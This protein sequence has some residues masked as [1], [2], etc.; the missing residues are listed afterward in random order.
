MPILPIDD[1]HSSPADLPD[2]VGQLSALQSLLRQSGLVFLSDAPGIRSVSLPSTLHAFLLQLIPQLI[3]GNPL[4][5]EIGSEEL[6][7]Q[8]AAEIL[9]VSRPFLV[10]LLDFGKIPHYL[11]GKHRRVYRK[12]LLEYKQFRDLE[13]HQALNRIA[14]ADENAGIYDKV[15]LPED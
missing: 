3:R 9:G 10:K 14:R 2:P 12:D 5:M 7:T 15:L 4:A 11:V 8:E 6:T 13:R 1:T